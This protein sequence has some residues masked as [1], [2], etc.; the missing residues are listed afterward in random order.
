MNI[1]TGKAKIKIESEYLVTS[2]THFCSSA[3]HR[4]I[5]LYLQIPLRKQDVK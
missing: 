1:N 4:E 3:A 5:I 2:A